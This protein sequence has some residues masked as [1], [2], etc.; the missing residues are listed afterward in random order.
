MDSHP[1]VHV[2]PLSLTRQ[3]NSSN[4]V[5]ADEELY[6]ELQ[7]IENLPKTSQ[8]TPSICCEE[9][10]KYLNDDTLYIAL[11]S[12]LSGTFN[13]AR[14]GLAILKETEKVNNFYIFD[15]R[16]VSNGQTIFIDIALDLINKGAN[17]ETIYETLCQ[18]R[19]NINI[20]FNIP[21]LN[22]VY[23]GGRLSKTEAV[24]GTLL[25]IKPIVS[26]KNGKPFI[27]NKIRGTKQANHYILDKLK[28]KEIDHLYFSFGR[29]TKEVENFIEELDKLNISYTSLR[30]SPILATHIGPN[31]YGISFTTK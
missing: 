15:S 30:L 16:N 20:F 8:A 10:K 29:Y 13:S 24:A 23:K 22:Y 17:I 25:Q 4:A 5:F 28:G 3:N 7:D 1:N 12:E 11:S 19:N 6:T 31:S 9:F 27:E 21:D 18:V 14:T 2:L 26:M